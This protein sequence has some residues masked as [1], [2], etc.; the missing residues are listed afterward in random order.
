MLFKEEIG[1]NENGR[2]VFSFPVSTGYF[3]RY[4]NASYT[5]KAGQT[6]AFKNPKT[7]IQNPVAWEIK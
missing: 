6:R 2:I 4:L 5:R 1:K 7:P 3:A